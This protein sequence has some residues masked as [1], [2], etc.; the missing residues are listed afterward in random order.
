MDEYLKFICKLNGEFNYAASRAKEA[1]DDKR[2]QY[3]KSISKGIVHCIEAY[4]GLG[5]IEK[6]NEFDDLDKALEEAKAALK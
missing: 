5:K 2:Y 3:Y 4:E 6:E 1:G